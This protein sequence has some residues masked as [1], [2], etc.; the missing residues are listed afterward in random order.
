MTVYLFIGFLLIKVLSIDVTMEMYESFDSKVGRTKS[1]R[2]VVKKYLHYFI[3][4]LV[5]ITS[6]IPCLQFASLPMKYPTD[7]NR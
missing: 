7:P 3:Y 1:G 2:P 5:A 6:F 4:T